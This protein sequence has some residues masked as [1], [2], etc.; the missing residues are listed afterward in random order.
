MRGI[1]KAVFLIIAIIVVIILIS[2]YLYFGGYYILSFAFPKA[3]LEYQI[4]SLCSEWVQNRCTVSSASPP[5]GI[6]MIADNKRVFLK[7]LCE[8]SYGTESVAGD[9]WWTSCKEFCKGCQ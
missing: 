8:Q 5:D 1:E 7:E 9:K 6:S 3:K 4:S 2:I